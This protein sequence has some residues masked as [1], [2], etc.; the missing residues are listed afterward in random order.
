MDE[1]PPRYRVIRSLGKGG[2]G[3]VFL[4]EDTLLRTMPQAVLMDD[5]HWADEPTLLCSNTSRSGC[6]GDH[7]T[8]DGMLKQAQQTAE[9]RADGRLLAQVLSNQVLFHHAYSE[10]NQAVESGR[11]AAAELRRVGDLWE[12]ASVLGFVEIHLSCLGRLNESAACDEEL[13]PIADRLGHYGA[14]LCADGTRAVCQL[15]RTAHLDAFEAY[16]RHSLEWSK[17]AGPWSW[18]GHLYL[19]TAQFWKGKWQEALANI[20]SAMRLEKVPDWID[21]PWGWLF[22]VKAYAGDADALQVFTG[23]RAAVPAPSKP[24]F[25]GAWHVVQLA[26]EGLAVLGERREAH[27]LYPIPESSGAT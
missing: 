22:L 14:L 12:L 2:M 7:G 23:K 4:T 9:R 18:L 26:V 5:L 27:A 13:R 16:G 1:S 19:G 6:R 17:R 11:R 3:E 10:Y 20:E 21:L 25:G 8:G 15:M 24:S